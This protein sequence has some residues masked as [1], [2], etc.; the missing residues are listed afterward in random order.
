MIAGG[1]LFKSY[2]YR[3]VAIRCR[4]RYREDCIKIEIM[5]KTFPGSADSGRVP[6]KIFKIVVGPFYHWWWDRLG[7]TATNLENK[8]FWADFT[9]SHRYR[10]DSG[11]EPANRRVYR[12]SRILLLQLLA[13]KYCPPPPIPRPSKN[14]ENWKE[15][16][17]QIILDRKRLLPLSRNIQAK[18]HPLSCFLQYLDSISEHT[19]LLSRWKAFYII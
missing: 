1:S 10:H 3:E 17:I 18:T 2:R 19:E 8:K 5:K 7:P 4:L 11:W 12:I 14:H 15:N 9:S 6:A 13:M 16:S